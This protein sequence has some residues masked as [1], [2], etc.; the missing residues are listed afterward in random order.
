MGK[1]VIGLILIEESFHEATTANLED[2]DA[3]LE[4]IAEFDAAN[5][6]MHGGMA[7]AWK[8]AKDYGG[9]VKDQNS[10]GCGWIC[11][12]AGFPQSNF[13]PLMRPG[14]PLAF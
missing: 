10:R 3:I 5:S 9:L 13:Y 2:K 12:Q 14:L 11:Q 8:R 6:Y 4:M 1:S 7:S